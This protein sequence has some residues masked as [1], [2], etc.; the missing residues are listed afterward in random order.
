MFIGIKKTK[1]FMKRNVKKFIA[2]MCIIAIAF[3]TGIASL[4]YECNNAYASEVKDY[5]DVLSIYGVYAKKV[6]LDD[7]SHILDVAVDIC[8]N[9]LDTNKYNFGDT[10]SLRMDVSLVNS[11]LEECVVGNF[12]NGSY[13]GSGITDSFSCVIGY[14]DIGMTALYNSRNFADEYAYQADDEPYEIPSE[15]ATRK[16]QLENGYSVWD[17]FYFDFSKIKIDMKV[18]DKN[19]T[20]NLKSFYINISDVYKSD[21]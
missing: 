7:G 8:Y 6:D 5:S 10:A 21:M 12:G 9:E 20:V 15:L 1:S 18:V 3:S 14:D 4:I 11:D 2:F 19:N 13:I 17:C 16:G